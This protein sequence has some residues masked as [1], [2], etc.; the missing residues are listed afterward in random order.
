MWLELTSSMTNRYS[1]GE[2]V[3]LDGTAHDG[4][5]GTVLKP[6]GEDEYLVVLEDGTQVL[7]HQESL[8]LRH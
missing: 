6:V 8:L 1:E 4:K 7:V 5:V 3:L 2:A